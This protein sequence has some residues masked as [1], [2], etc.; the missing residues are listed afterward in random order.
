MSTQEE[1][2]RRLQ[3][4]DDLTDI[5]ET[6]VAAE[7]ENC[8]VLH[9]VLTPH[10]QAPLSP[11]PPESPALSNAPGGG[12]KGI[13]TIGADDGAGDDGRRAALRRKRKAEGEIEKLSRQRG[14][15]TAPTRTNEGFKLTAGAMQS[16]MPDAIEN[17][18]KMDGYL[19]F[20]TAR[21]RTLAIPKLGN[22]LQASWASCMA[23]L[24][25]LS[26]PYNLVDATARFQSG[27]P[28]LNLLRATSGVFVVALLVEIQGKK[29]DH[30]VAYSAARG[31]LIDNGSKT[32]PLYIEDED[33]RGKKAARNAFR[34][35][36]A[37]KVQAGT[38]FSVDVTEIFELSR[39]CGARG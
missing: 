29:N 32:K 17:A 23:A 37:Q 1:Q 20:S 8:C 35:L 14:A 9:G 13:V 21:L 30:C 16:C 18:M 33:R 31:V 39:I 27:P 34:Q 38:H 28:M 5:D 10:S 24:S 3:Y 12:P 15:I 22:I 25:K 4:N 19:D 7:T 6:P 36:V 11:T 2:D 26:L